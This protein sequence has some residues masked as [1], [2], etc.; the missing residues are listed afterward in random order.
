MIAITPDH[1]NNAWSRDRLERRL[2]ARRVQHPQHPA[3]FTPRRH[4]QY[5]LSVR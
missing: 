1:S 4:R 5:E 3:R 2:R